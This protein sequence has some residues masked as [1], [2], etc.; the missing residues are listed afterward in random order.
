MPTA[1]AELVT[2]PQRENV[3]AAELL[4]A[5]R[6]EAD[7]KR[8]CTLGL[9]SIATEIE[10]FRGEMQREL[11]LLCG[12]DKF[13]AWRSFAIE[14]KRKLREELAKLVNGPEERIREHLNFNK[15]ETLSYLR[16]LNLDVASIRKLNHSALEKYLALVKAPANSP[17]SQTSTTPPKVPKTL[18][19]WTTI[20]APYPAT[21]AWES[22]EWLRGFWKAGYAPNAWIDSSSGLLGN[23]NFICDSDAGDYDVG[24]YDYDAYVTLW[25]K[26]PSAGLLEMYIE[27][28][29]GNCNHFISL[30]DEWGGSNAYARQNCFWFMQAIGSQRTGVIRTSA[31]TLVKSGTDAKA[32]MSLQPGLTQWAHLYSDVPFRKDEWVYI[33]AGIQTHNDCFANDVRVESSIYC[34]WC[35]KS[36][37]MRS[38]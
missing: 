33:R 22:R 32:S 1:E 16:K 25:Y 7:F 31:S 38:T 30:E 36:I 3:P 26:M 28:Q 19:T 10:Q 12:P 24:I 35:L 14:Q 34:K 2:V 27:G 6:S 21:Y 29:V 4:A 8:D 15:N 23:I 13:E 11:R 20:R 18:S 37:W 17:G 9:V 5:L